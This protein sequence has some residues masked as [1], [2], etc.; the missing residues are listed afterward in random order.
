MGV[1]ARLCRILEIILRASY[2]MTYMQNHGRSVSRG[3]TSRTEFNM[4]TPITL[5]AGERRDG[6][7]KRMEERPLVRR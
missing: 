7:K 6:N 2:L 4:V 5:A 1:G 3:V